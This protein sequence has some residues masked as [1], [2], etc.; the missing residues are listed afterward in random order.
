MP[1]D[2]ENLQA[3]VLDESGL[4]AIRALDEDGGD[5]LVREILAAYFAS[6]PGLLAQLDE[7]LAA[8]NVEKV[9][10]ATHTLKS[11]SANLGALR[12]ADLCK[13]AET[14]AR[15]DDL[16]TALKLAPSIHQTYR[17]TCEA[18]ARSIAG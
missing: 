4:D 15:S 17:Q 8:R 13:A 6:S 14:A 7:G 18:L 1:L 12:L 11:S 9:R 10:I 3:P 5:V 2:L 16:G